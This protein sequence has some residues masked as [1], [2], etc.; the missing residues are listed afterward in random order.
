[1][2]YFGMGFGPMDTKPHKREYRLIKVKQHLENK[3]IREKYN[4]PKD[5]IKFKKR[6]EGLITEFEKRSKDR[7][8]VIHIVFIII[9]LLVIIAIIKIV[10]SLR[11]SYYNVSYYQPYPREQVF[12]GTNIM[13][14]S[15]EP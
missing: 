15:Y 4:I 1:V 5:E 2:S 7:K 6:R 14:Q 3:I 11:T 12:P 10:Y 8:S 13:K 9:L